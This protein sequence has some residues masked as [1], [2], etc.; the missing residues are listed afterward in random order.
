MPTGY[1]AAIADG[2]DFE[3]FVLRCAHA[4]GALVTLRDSGADSPIPEFKPE[5]YHST[6]LGEAKRHLATLRK[7]GAK[8]A[9][10]EAEKEWARQSTE[11]DRYV[12]GKRTLRAKYE[13]MLKQVEAW[14]PPTHDHQGLKKFMAEQLIT[15]IEHDC[16]ESY[17]ERYAPKHLTGGAWLAR[18]TA[19]AER[20]INYHTAEYAKEVARCAE[21]NEWV[22]AL[23]ASLTSKESK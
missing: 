10:A 20:N 3:Q 22:R 11:H 7:M 8:Q 2:I 17:D 6:A 19:E 21:R 18:K 16:D 13:A 9:D 12:K 4:F 1:T 15:S 5:S 14:K 23:R